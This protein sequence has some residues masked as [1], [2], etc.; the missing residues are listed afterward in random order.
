MVEYE[1]RGRELGAELLDRL[2]VLLERAEDADRHLELPT[3]RDDRP[4][5]VVIEWVLWVPPERRL[6]AHAAPAQAMHPDDL[7]GR[8]V[9]R[10]VRVDDQGG[11]EFSWVLLQLGGDDFFTCFLLL[12]AITFLS[13]S[14]L[15]LT[16]LK[17]HTT[18]RK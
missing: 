13:S 15:F 10:E 11:L 9:R 3:L 8:R 7:G 5:S 1:R 2:A 6:E 12:S 18:I 14:L 16:P 17:S 4:A